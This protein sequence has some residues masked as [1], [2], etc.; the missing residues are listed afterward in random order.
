GVADPCR[1]EGPADGGIAG[2]L[3]R[4]R[5]LPR[6]A[7]GPG[8]A[9]GDFRCRARA[10]PCRCLETQG[11][12]AARSQLAGAGRLTLRTK[13]V[14]REMVRSRRLELPRLSTQRPQRCAS[15]NSATTARRGRSCARGA[16]RGCV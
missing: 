4:D 7:G 5:S 15:T 3:F 2:N 16:E 6:L 8:A 13:G 14:V 1:G 10:A 11:A 12:E 9:R